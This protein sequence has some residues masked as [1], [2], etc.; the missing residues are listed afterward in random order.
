MFPVPVRSSIR[1]PST[2]PPNSVFQLSGPHCT[3]RPRGLSKSA[4]SR[5]ILIRVTPFRVLITLLIT[6]LLSPLGLEVGFG[7]PIFDRS[8][9]SGARARLW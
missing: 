1:D 8:A 9:P 6:R 2:D 7:L 3:W 4:I 5:L